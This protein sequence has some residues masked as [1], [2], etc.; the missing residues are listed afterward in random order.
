M[1]D[2]TKEKIIDY[3]KNGIEENKHLDYKAADALGKSD[4]CKKEISKD[5]SAF[6]N[7]DGGIIIYGIKEFDD[8]Q[9][10][11]LP[12]KIDPINRLIYSKEWLEN[13]ITGNI[14]PIIDKISITPVTIDDELNHCVY[15]VEIDKSNTAH[16]S[17]DNRYYK[18][19]EFKSSPMDDWEVKD[20][21][22]R[23]TKPIIEVILKAHKNRYIDRVL[24]GSP[25]QIKLLMRNTGNSAVSH[26]NCY[27][28][29]DKKY[30]ALLGE[31]AFQINGNLIQLTI[32][33]KVFNTIKINGEESVIST[34]TMPL[35]PGG[36]LTEI[37]FVSVKPDLIKEDLNIHCIINTEFGIIEKEFQ[38]DEIK[39]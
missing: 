13:I 2:W 16:Q 32:T 34:S 27:L 21:I 30:G 17:S 10:K 6:A 37:G 31:S 36:V 22:N 3:I 14:S 20:V 12:E 5:V 39:N 15:V 24:T 1:S 33:N 28:L 38:M 25:S 7:S 11:H 18:R 23:S 26:I 8:P 4:G 29:I 9:K 35:L 19:R